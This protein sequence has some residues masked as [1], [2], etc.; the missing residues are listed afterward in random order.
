LRTVEPLSG[1]AISIPTFTLLFLLLSPLVLQGEPVVWRALPAFMAI[2]LFFPAALTLLT[3]ASNRALGPVITSTIGNLAPLFS[4]TV[5]VAL[6][7]EPLHPPQLLGL[8]VAVAGAAIITVT[9]PRD[10]GHWRSWALLLP[11][12]S[13][14]VRGATPPIMKL[15]LEIWPSPLWAC[16]IGYVMSSLVVL[17]VQRIR[18]GSF[19]VQAPR[20]GRFWFAMTGISNGLSALSLFIAIRNGPITLV[21]PLAAIYPLVTVALSAMLLKHIEITARIVVGTALTVLGVAL[22]LIG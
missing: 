12:C 22:V 5:A 13:A 14:L 19:M 8:V 7:Q 1:A 2:G 6:L 17:T 20:A 4:V 10:L 18:K 16:L 15:G 9:R 11:L 3:F 21:A